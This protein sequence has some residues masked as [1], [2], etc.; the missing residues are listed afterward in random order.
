MGFVGNA[1]LGL[2]GLVLRTALGGQQP[3]GY[4]LGLTISHYKG[5]SLQ[6]AINAVYKKEV[7]DS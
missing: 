6:D 5:T 3:A 7:G 1:H 2:I 4:L